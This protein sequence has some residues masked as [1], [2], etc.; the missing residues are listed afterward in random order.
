[1]AFFYLESPI[2][3]R[4]ARSSRS[5]Y[6]V[7]KHALSVHIATRMGASAHAPTWLQATFNT[8]VKRR[9]AGA[10]CHHKCKTLE[11]KAFQRRRA[12]KKPCESVRM[13]YFPRRF[14]LTRTQWHRVSRSHGFIRGVPQNGEKGWRTDQVRSPDPDFQRHITL[15]QAS[16]QRLRFARR[17]YQEEPA[18]Q[19]PVHHARP[20]E[21][22]GRQEARHEG[23]RR[24]QSFHRRKD[25]VQGQA[26]EQEGSCDAA[27]EPEG[28][29]QLVSRHFP[30]GAKPGLA[31]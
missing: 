6:A 17:R 19:W 21:D 9:V 10:A 20:A 22:E 14:S 11:K 13:C 27:Q 25:D 7:K 28:D 1:M 24:Y 4:C 16:Q 29:G 3:V 8:H 5:A 23:A 15:T 30:P 31:L 12:P 26:R 2:C 18:R